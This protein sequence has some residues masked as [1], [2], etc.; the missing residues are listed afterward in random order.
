[1]VSRADGIVTMARWHDEHDGFTRFVI[2]SIVASFPCDGAEGVVFRQ[3][4]SSAI[5][6]Y[7]RTDRWVHRRTRNGARSTRRHGA[8]LRSGSSW[9]RIREGLAG[10][11]QGSRQ[12]L[13]QSSQGRSQAEGCS[14]R[15]SQEARN[16]D[17]AACLLLSGTGLHGCGRLVLASSPTS[18]PSSTRMMGS[19]CSMTAGTRGCRTRS[20]LPSHRCWTVP[21]R[22]KRSFDALADDYPAEQIF[23]AM[24]HLRTSGYLAEDAAV[25]ARPALAFW[26]HAGVP[27]RSRERVSASRQ[28]RL[29][30]SATLTPVPHGTARPPRDCRGA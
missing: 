21:T 18:S 5:S 24:D 10:V 1:M 16:R 22:S 6:N 20:T 9:N 30:R 28:W 25:E 4:P 15:G 14:R 19:L 13:R 7:R 27:R 11:R 29:W 12:D 3:R 2:V 8:T 26:E 23:A 17:R